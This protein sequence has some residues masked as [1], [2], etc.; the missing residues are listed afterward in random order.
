[1]DYILNP[2]AAMSM[3]RKRPERGLHTGHQED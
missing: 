1:M 3:A 2:D